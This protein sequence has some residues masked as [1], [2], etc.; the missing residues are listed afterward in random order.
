[1]RHGVEDRI[2]ELAALLRQNGLRVSPGEVSDAVGA[3]ALLGLD[4]RA[5]VRAA[6]RSTLVKR[7]RDAPVFDR[8]FELYF[9]GLAQLLEGLEKSLLDQ[10]AEEGFFS[11]D[12]RPFQS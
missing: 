2:I 7:G 10:L 11:E 4:D 12:S 8:L 9:G 3:L 6:L 5:T 1:M